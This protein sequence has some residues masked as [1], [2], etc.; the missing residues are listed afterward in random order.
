MNILN[1]KG[2]IPFLI[3]WLDKIFLK[4]MDLEGANCLA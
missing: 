3:V 1:S 2:S 4:K